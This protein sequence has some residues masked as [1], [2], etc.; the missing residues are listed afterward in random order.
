MPLSRL[1][2]RLATSRVVPV[3]ASR[4]DSGRDPSGTLNTHPFG[5][6]ALPGK[7]L[8][9]AAWNPEE[10]RK[11]AN[12]LAI[13]LAINRRRGQPDFQAFAMSSVKGVGRGPGLDVDG[14]YQVFTVPLVPMRCQ[15]LM[16]YPDRVL[17]FCLQQGAVSGMGEVE[18]PG[19]GSFTSYTPMSG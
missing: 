3:Y 6:A 18:C 2:C 5:P 1:S 11:K 4:G 14:Q 15:G 16:L 7:Q 13:C 12:E 9:L 10:F 8:D 17:R 19:S